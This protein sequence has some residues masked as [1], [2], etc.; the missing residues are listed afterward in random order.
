MRSD[1]P[2]SRAWKPVDYAPEDVEAIQALKRGDATP[3]QQSR[4]L[5]WIINSAAGAYELSYRTDEDGGDRE[6]AFAE[7]RRF[8]G[9]SVVKM[10]SLTGTAIAAMRGAK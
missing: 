1:K 8:G 4:A 6:T 3:S 2:R 5:D 7:G 9:R 10:L